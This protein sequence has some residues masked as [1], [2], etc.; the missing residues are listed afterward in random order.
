MEKIT[1]ERLLL[2]LKSFPSYD[3]DMGIGDPEKSHKRAD[4][5]LL[6]YIN[7]EEITE[8]FENLIRWYS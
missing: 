3:D 4:E 7:D 6:R 8:A 1:K 5:L 2:E